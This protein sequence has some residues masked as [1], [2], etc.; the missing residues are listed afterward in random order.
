MLHKFGRHSGPS[1]V[2]ATSKQANRIKHIA[3]NNVIFIFLD[4]SILLKSFLSSLYPNKYTS[5]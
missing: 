5:I 1:V 2:E 4:V 3:A